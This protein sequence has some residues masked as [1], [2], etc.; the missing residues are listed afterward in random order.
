MPN[1]GQLTV[2]ADRHGGNVRVTFTDTGLGFSPGALARHAEL[3]YSEKEGGM[4]IG[5]SVTAEILKAHR[6]VLSVGNQ[7]ESGARV[8]FL[9][10]AVD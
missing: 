6:G 1:G 3:F 5:L 7:P 10:P 9:I 2:A 4:G 8:T